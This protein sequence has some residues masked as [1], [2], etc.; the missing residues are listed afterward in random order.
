MGYEISTLQVPL[1]Q[2]TSKRTSKIQ[3]AYMLEDEMFE[4]VDSIKIRRCN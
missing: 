1:M 2:L 4:D 3:A